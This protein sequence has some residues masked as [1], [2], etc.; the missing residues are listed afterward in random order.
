MGEVEADRDPDGPCLRVAQV[1]TVEL[2]REHSSPCSLPPRP[3]PLMAYQD[4][5]SLNNTFQA[6]HQGNGHLLTSLAPRDPNQGYGCRRTEYPQQLP[7][8]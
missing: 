8:L 1:E 4:L 2:L 5:I 7:K 3:W 6:H